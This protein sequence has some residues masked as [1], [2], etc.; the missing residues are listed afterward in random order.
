MTVTRI[1]CRRRRRGLVSLPRCR[2]PSVR[3]PLGQCD[4][5]GIEWRRTTT[6]R[7]ST[8][9]NNNTPTVLRTD[10]DRAS[11]R[12]CGN[13]RGMNRNGRR[14]VELSEWTYNNIESRAEKENDWI[15]VITINSHRDKFNVH[16]TD[17]IQ[18]KKKATAVG[19][20]RTNAFEAN[21]TASIVI[22]L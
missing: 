21:T 15:P 14:C 2:L 5:N 1:L 9:L 10:W 13:I 3:P 22:F 20:A 17:S 18:E 12:V 19:V 8:G 11:G 16:L 4:M 6:D 7:H